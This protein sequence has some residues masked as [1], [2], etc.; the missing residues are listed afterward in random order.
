[1]ESKRKAL[2]LAKKFEIVQLCERETVSKSEI[3][4]R[5]GLSSSTLFTILKNKEKIKS[6]FMMQNTPGGCKKLRP[7]DNTELESILFEWFTQQR[8]LGIPISG[9]MIKAKAEEIA[10][11]MK[12]DNFRSTD[13]WLNR[14]KGRRGISLH[15]ISGESSEVNMQA[16]H[17][18][19]P[20]LKSILERY[21]EKVSNAKS[22]LSFKYYKL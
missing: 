2:E 17:D 12:L 16:V 9:T 11:R 8:S 5:Y 6:A 22:K 7:A 20:I 13:G 4:R 15:I 19:L 3:G 21:E 1:M 14:F 10:L 18:W